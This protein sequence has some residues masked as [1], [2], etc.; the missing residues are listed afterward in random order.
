MI[1]R[2]GSQ[3]SAPGPA[4][5]FTGEVR[6]QPLF[7]AQDAAPYTGGAVTF[8][9]GA[10]TA[11]HVH[12]GGQRLVVTDGVGRTQQWGGPVEQFRAGDVVWCP[13][14]VKHWHGAGPD[15]PMTHL[16]LTGVRDGQVVEWLEHVTDE[17]Y[18]AV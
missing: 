15:G 4:E 13:P 3:P 14:G 2:S 7:G 16:A 12:P 17:Q 10:R 5:S 11:W 6:I 18:G 8:S 1:T 9:P